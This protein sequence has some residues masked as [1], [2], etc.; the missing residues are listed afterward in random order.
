MTCDAIKRP[1]CLSQQ[2]HKKAFALPANQI[3]FLKEAPI[4][5]HCREGTATKPYLRVAINPIMPLGVLLKLALAVAAAAAAAASEPDVIDHHAQNQVNWVQANGGYFN[6][7]LEFHHLDPDD[8]SSSPSGLF[9]NNDV[10][11]GE[12]LM[13]I[14]QKCLLKSSEDDE[15]LESICDTVRNLVA[16]YKLGEEGHYWPYVRYIMDERHRG[17]LPSEWSKEGR[18]LLESII[19]AGLLPEFNATDVSFVAHCEVDQDE[20]GA[21]PLEEFAHFAVLRRSWDD[22]MVPLFDMVN[23]RN[24][25]WTNVESNSVHEGQDIRVHATRDIEAGEQLHRSYNECIDCC[26]YAHTYTLPDIMR[27]FGFVEQYPQRWN[28][29]SSWLMFEVDEVFDEN[30]ENTDAVEVI[31]FSDP[32]D[33]FDGLHVLHGQLRR[34]ERKYDDVLARASLLDSDHE[35]RVIVNFYDSLTAALDAIIITTTANFQEEEEARANSYSVCTADDSDE[36]T[37]SISSQPYLYDDLVEAHGVQY[38]EHICDFSIAHDRERYE[39]VEEYQSHYQ[40][41]TYRYSEED[42]DTCLYL[43][44]KFIAG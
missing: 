27:E 6:P 38:A 37:C 34:L 36:E 20:E 35:K 3:N 12:V 28:F 26:C 23:H 2:R 4:R 42:D 16:Q 14:P 43:D 24:G 39:V 31:W 21:G 10:A 15:T 8:T 5:R 32:P 25:R 44:G 18:E 19:P 1:F 22:I 40:T 30:D 41:L 29:R 9:V 7:K 17:D 11:E 33:D 13:I